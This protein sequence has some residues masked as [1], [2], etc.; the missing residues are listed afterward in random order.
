MR[1][2]RYEKK[3]ILLTGEKNN[4]G[5]EPC[6]NFSNSFDWFWGKNIKKHEVIPNLQQ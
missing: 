3:T 1:S 4:I 2:L 6:E 5:F